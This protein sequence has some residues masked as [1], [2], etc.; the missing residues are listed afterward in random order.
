MFGWKRM[1]LSLEARINAMEERMTDLATAE[2]VAALTTEVEGIKTTFDTNVASW[3][4]Q[5][6]AATAEIATLQ[7][8]GTPGVDLSALSAIITALHADVS[9][10]TLTPTAPPTTTA[11]A[12]AAA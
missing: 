6:G 1:C 2:S 8:A 5:L 10:A 11:E 12:P 4:A 3:T 9:S 7:A